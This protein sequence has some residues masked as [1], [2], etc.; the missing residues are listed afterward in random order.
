MKLIPIILTYLL[1]S[2]SLSAQDIDIDFILEQVKKNNPDIRMKEI[3]AEISKKEVSKSFK[4]LILP[5]VSL[6]QSKNLDNLKSEDV[7]FSKLEA[8]VPIFEGGKSYYTYKQSKVKDEI[9]KKEVFLTTLEYQEKAIE[10]YFNVLNYRKQ[11]DITNSVLNSLKNQ[12]SRLTKLFQSEQQI[13]LSEIYK[14][15]ADIELNNAINIEN[16]Q[17]EQTNIEYLYA[18]L[19]VN[20]NSNNNFLDFSIDKYLKNKINYAEDESRLLKDSSIVKK[21]KLK[22][23]SAEYDLKLAKS[24]LYPSVYAGSK[25]VIYDDEDDSNEGWM[26]EAGFKWLFAWGGTLDSISQKKKSLEKSKIDY[27]NNLNDLT[28][29]FREQYRVMQSLYGQ[30]LAHKKRIELL[31]NNLVLDTLRYD[32]QLISTFDYLNSVNELKK[33]Q[34]EYYKLQRKLVLATIK[35]ENLAR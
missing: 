1:F 13:A 19:G 7:K 35:Y 34:E 21:E 31:N 25:Y 3:E 15:D 4:N 33:S 24:E 30:L 18:I 20:L 28:V 23:E 8:T 29:K 17:N 6:S 14:I 5:P 10:H 2:I 9:M 26:V 32:N 27:E 16:K 12:S 22:V 11:I